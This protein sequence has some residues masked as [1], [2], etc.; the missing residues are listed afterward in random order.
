MDWHQYL[1]RYED[2]VENLKDLES[3]RAEEY[4]RAILSAGGVETPEDWRER[5]RIGSDRKQSGTAR[6][7]LT[8]KAEEIAIPL[9]LPDAQKRLVDLQSPGLRAFLGYS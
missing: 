6:E 1:V 5:V 9:E 3:N 8:G 4:F 2:L 7:N